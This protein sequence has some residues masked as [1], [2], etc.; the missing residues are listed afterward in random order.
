MQDSN[1]E[2]FKKVEKLEE[3]EKEKKKLTTRDLIKNKKIEFDISELD[4]LKSLK[5]VESK[6]T[7]INKEIIYKTNSLRDNFMQEFGKSFVKP[8][9]DTLQFSHTT[10]NNKNEL[11]N[12]NESQFLF[13]NKT[14]KVSHAELPILKLGFDQTTPEV[15]KH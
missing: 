2:F 3:K 14:V 1:D 12:S 5:N 6:D 13:N 15:K 8:S 9:Q 11:F 7:I 4:S 10:N